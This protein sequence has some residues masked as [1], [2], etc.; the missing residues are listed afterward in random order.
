M[1][2]MPPAELE[3][4]LKTYELVKWGCP[5]I[6]RFPRS[7]RCTLGD[8][9]ELRMYEV[10]DGLIR[11]KFDRNRAEILRYVNVELELLRFQVRLAHDLQC[12]HDSSYAHASKLINEIGV[13]V[14][15]WLRSCSPPNS[16]ERR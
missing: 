8:R 5:L 15:G 10:L 7:F 1:Q 4:I 13:Q 14:G 16:Q 6:S 11:A 2:Q 9:M 12:F 3:V